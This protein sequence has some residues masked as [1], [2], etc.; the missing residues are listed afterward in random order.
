MKTIRVWDLPTRLFH[1]L[2]AACV[3]A[4]VITGKIGGAAIDWHARLGYCVLALL[5]FRIVWGLFGGY[6]SRFSSFIFSPAS[7]L[8]YLKGN[9]RPEH[10][11]GHNPLG[12]F[13]VF[14]LLLILLAQVSTGLVSDD[15]ISFTGPLT[16]F[17]SGSLSLGATAYHKSIG[18]WGILALVGLHVAAILFYRFKKGINLVSPMVLGDKAVD[19]DVPA[20]RDDLASRMLALVILAICAGG[21]YWVTRLGS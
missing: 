1:W 8:A 12:A 11:V 18:Q 7:V 13:S 4:L 17:V 5:A 15:E 16:K 9:G 20:S 21:A 6:W 19:G 14:A 10:S 2:L 3:I